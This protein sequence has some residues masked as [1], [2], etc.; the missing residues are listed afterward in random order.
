MLGDIHTCPLRGHST[1]FQ[2]VDESGDGQPYAGLAY[3]VTDYEDVVYTG[4]LDATGSGKVE[5]HYCG[6]V[7][8]KFNQL[9]Q[10][11][12]AP[13]VRLKER[14]AY[15]LPIT[16]LQVRAEKTR[17]FNK[18]GVRTKLNPAQDKT[19]GYCQV[20]VRELVEHV[21]HLPPLA[22][23]NFPPDAYVHALFR[24]P[25]KAP[26]VPN[27]GMGSV[28]TPTDRATAQLGFAPEPPKAK[29][30]A[31]LPNRHHVLEVRPLRAL[32]PVLS[33]DNEF[34]AL[35]QYQ[36]ALMATLS[37]TDFGQDP[38]TH[39]VQ[40][41][42]VSFP[43][44]PS[45]GNWFGEALSKFEELWQVDTSQ[46]G[47]NPYYPLYEEVPYSK[48]LEIAPF[49]PQLYP[50]VNSPDLGDKQE[51]PERLHY[52][53][54]ADKIDRTDTQAYI[55]HHDELVLI[56]VRGTAGK[57][58][59]YRDLDAAQV[60]FE[61][62]DGM[63]HR[64][65]YDSAKAVRGFVA[66]YL[67]KFH[68]GQKI[69]VTGHSLGGAVAMILSQML[70]KRKGFSYDVLLYTYGAPRSG[71]TPFV[72]SAKGLFHHRTVNHNDPVPSLPA[73]WMN[74]SKPTYITGAALTFINAPLGVAFF[75]AGLYNFKGASYAHHG[76]LR[77]FMPVTFED[78]HQ[79]AI[80]WTP[81]CSTIIDQGC[82]K[83][84][85][86]TDGLPARGPFLRQVLDFSD[87]K[88]VVSYIPNCWATLRRWQESQE[89]G[90]WLVTPREFDFI[91]AA[92]ANINKQ[93]LAKQGES[94]SQGR[95]PV[96]A[97][98][99]AALEAE[100][101]KVDETRT[102]LSDLRHTTARMEEVYGLAATHED[103]AANLV[104]WRAHAVNTAAEQL[105]MAPPAA[106]DHD[107]Q[108]AASTGG[109]VVGAPFNL[110]IDAL[111]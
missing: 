77:H 109:H 82:A 100:S 96:Q 33:I 22:A 59:V 49:D 53:D 4:K 58:D 3:E 44:Q 14:K 107:Q 66:K 75:F 48:R 105:A 55:T 35:N 20:E 24:Q 62:G 19:N 36:L 42:S 13:Y 68:S 56:A 43:S 16:E 7:V 1:S 79:S 37:Y 39:P 21:A 11:Q 17:F 60:P 46:S 69:V 57:P 102:R 88:M 73:T 108:I 103:L 91:D 65:F 110:D 32:R 76:T 111:V 64:G 61:E 93:L 104:R 85:Q 98:D 40:A 25:L 41:D 51:T 2:L 106:I 27:T 30:V 63:V 84:L 52:F 89:F 67:D 9:Y 23:R 34:C 8:L 99:I 74:T 81:G 83:A 80:L 97:R 47:G 54:D 10:G 71:D 15:R 95:E 6:P 18:T 94:S 50:E 72:D 87:H 28:I 29:G 101:R 26:N 38:N 31:L 78:G 92:L 86:I 5:H 45:S 90:R 70:R 12:E